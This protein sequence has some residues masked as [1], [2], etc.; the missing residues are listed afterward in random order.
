MH[1]LWKY[2]LL[3]I[4]SYVLLIVVSAI[5]FRAMQ[6]WS[7]ICNC[8]IP[9]L[10]HTIQPTLTL[11]ESPQ[12]FCL[13][14]SYYLLLCHPPFSSPHPVLLVRLIAVCCAA[15]SKCILVTKN[16]TSCNNPF[17]NIPIKKFC[18][19]RASNRPT[20][21][22][23]FYSTSTSSLIGHQTVAKD[24]VLLISLASNNRSRKHN[25]TALH[26][27][28]FILERRRLRNKEDD[29]ILFSPHRIQCL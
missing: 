13:L 10:F 7:Y 24:S 11:P 14:S 5:S 25:F 21:R 28:Q 27:H 22:N 18:C 17:I 4:A 1:G 15:R 29:M 9:I 8:S 19:Q 2:Y 12:L 26:K 20:K 23:N 3:P 16:S 6:N